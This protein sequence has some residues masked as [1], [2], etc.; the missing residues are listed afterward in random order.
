MRPVAA[1]RMRHYRRT[2]RIPHRARAQP[3]AVREAF[4][5]PTSCSRLPC[6]LADRVERVRGPREVALQEGIEARP[7]PGHHDDPSLDRR[8]DV[9][10][11]QHA[12]CQDA[13]RRVAR[14]SRRPRST[15]ATFYPFALSRVWPSDPRLARYE[16]ETGRDPRRMLQLQRVSCRAAVGPTLA[17]VGGG[18][19]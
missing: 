1:A 16:R 10:G 11:E 14:S 17:D 12:L 18:V 19:R 4:G 13:R 5:G 7:P 3:R 6:R 8:H 15:L 2:H 9:P